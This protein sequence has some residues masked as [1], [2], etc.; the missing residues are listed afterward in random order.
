MAGLTTLNEQRKQ[1]KILREAIESAIAT[2]NENGQLNPDLLKYTYPLYSAL[3]LAEGYA[4]CEAEDALTMIEGGYELKIVTATSVPI[5]NLRRH[6]SNGWIACEQGGRKRYLGADD[7]IY[8]KKAGTADD[9][10]E[11]ISEGADAQGTGG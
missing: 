5:T 4:Y 8:I 6:T 7:V 2:L 10:P 1:N 9:N 11:P 3:R